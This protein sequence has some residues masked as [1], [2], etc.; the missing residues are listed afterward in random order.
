VSETFT[1][2]LDLLK[3]RLQLQR[4]D[5]APPLRFA[6]L[7]RHVVRTEGARALFAGCTIAVARQWINAGVSV[8]LA[9]LL[10]FLEGR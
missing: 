5:A 4:G 8:G 3:T 7:I 10:F 6:A 1:Y 9:L 2:P